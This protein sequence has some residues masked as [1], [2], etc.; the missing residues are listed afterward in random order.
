MKADC[1]ASLTN[2]GG[3]KPPYDFLHD[4]VEVVQGRPVCNSREARAVGQRIH[5][6]LRFLL[7]FGMQRHREDK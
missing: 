1:S 6:H 4:A 3:R 5:F 7:D 2:G